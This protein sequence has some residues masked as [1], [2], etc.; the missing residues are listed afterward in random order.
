METDTWWVF[1]LNSYE[2]SFGPRYRSAITSHEKLTKDTDQT[3]LNEIWSLDIEMSEE[4]NAA[5]IVDKDIVFGKCMNKP[6]LM[7]TAWFNQT[8]DFGQVFASC[9]W[10]K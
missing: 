8:V 7:T 10:K 6:V 2:S 1:Q 3:L 9:W 5:F 4:K